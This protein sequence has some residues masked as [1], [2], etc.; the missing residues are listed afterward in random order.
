MRKSLRLEGT[1]LRYGN[2]FWSGASAMQD[3]SSRTESLTAWC[4][5]RT[6]MRALSLWKMML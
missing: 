4:E 6:R 2:G 3:G 5:G 1:Y